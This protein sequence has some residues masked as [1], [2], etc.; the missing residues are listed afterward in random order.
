MDQRGGDGVVQNVAEDERELV[1]EEEET[2]SA[3]GSEN[4]EKDGFDSAG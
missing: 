4:P 3:E 1:E 2:E